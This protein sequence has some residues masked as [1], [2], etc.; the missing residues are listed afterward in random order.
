MDQEDKEAPQGTT[1]SPGSCCANLGDVFLAKS[2][3]GEY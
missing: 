3:I 2:I 1:F